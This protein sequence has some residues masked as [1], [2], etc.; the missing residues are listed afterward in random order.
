MTTNLDPHPGEELAAKF[1]AAWLVFGRTCSHFVA[2]EAT[3]QAWFAHY[4]IS[5]FGIDRV[6]REPN[7]KHRHFT[8]RWA[9]H[10]P[11]GEVKLNVVVTRQQVWRCPTTRTRGDLGD[12]LRAVAEPLVCGPV[13]ARVADRLDSAARERAAGTG[14]GAQLVSGTYVPLTCRVRGLRYGSGMAH[15]LGYARVS[16]LEQNPDLQVDELTAAA[17]WR[18]WTDHGSGALDRRPQLDAVLEQLRPGTRWWCGGRT[19]W[20]GRCGT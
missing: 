6:A 18:V 15:L 12:G 20:A 16:T 4:L 11:G 1:E 7:F 13:R 2:P 14:C 10:A 19:G 3:Y 17:C 8:S 5:Q 9:E